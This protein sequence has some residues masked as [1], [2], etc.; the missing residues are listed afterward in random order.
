M[1]NTMQL[2]HSSLG[3]GLALCGVVLTVS[4]AACSTQQGSGAAATTAKAESP[5]APE[6]AAFTAAELGKPAPNFKLKD[7]DGNTVELSQL[8][9]KIVV[10][11]WFNPGCPFVK[12]NH[13]KGSLKGMAARFADKGIVWLA[14][15]SG[16]PGKQGH[17][18]EANKQGKES[19]GMTYP[20]LLD[21]SG[22]VGKTYGARTTPHM[23]V[24]NAQGVLVYRGAIDNTKGGEPEP[25]EKIVNHV[26]AALG[27]VVAGK[28]VSTAETESYGCSVKYASK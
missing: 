16:A 22:E 6:T 28:P 7:L 11:E 26:E 27:E 1:K 5:K 18:V 24:I 12:A 23:Y 8:K 19:F 4:A 14:V 13:S 15:N 2:I 10:L 25:G 17:G 9:G 21:E 3:R 20:I